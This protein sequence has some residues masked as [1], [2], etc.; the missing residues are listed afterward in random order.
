MQRRLDPGLPWKMSGCPGMD[1]NM[2][3]REG[4]VLDPLKVTLAQD[5]R[6]RAAT[7]MFHGSRTEFRP[8]TMDSYQ[9]ME[10]DTYSLYFM[11]NAVPRTGFRSL[12][13][14]L[15]ITGGMQL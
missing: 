9:N 11:R 14:L 13:E 6:K 15:E 1:G 5:C 3:L 12:R 4:S 10:N 8:T 7:D 2:Q